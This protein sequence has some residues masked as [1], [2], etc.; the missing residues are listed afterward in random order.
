MTFPY[1]IRKTGNDFQL[2]MT[3]DA[4]GWEYA[5]TG[6]L[7][8][9]RPESSEHRPDTAVKLLYND[10]GL[11]CLFKVEDKYV[12]CVHRQFQDSVCL[13]SC[14]EFFVQPLGKG[15]YFNFE[16]NCGGTCLIYY[17]MDANRTSKGFGN[18]EKL[19][20]DDL[21]ELS[22]QHSLPSLIP[23]EITEDTTWFLAFYAPFSLMRK[24]AGAFDSVDGRT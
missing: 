6:R 7:E 13:D 21:E 19:T 4:G 3:W 5:N 20:E 15:G 11:F 1:I 24:Y 16:F 23:E 12:R 17:I 8:N 10:H 22:V 9:V 14:V 18:Y 2:S